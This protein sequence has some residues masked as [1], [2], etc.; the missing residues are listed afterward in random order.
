MTRRSPGA[1]ESCDSSRRVLSSAHCKADGRRD[2]GDPSTRRSGWCAARHR[3]RALGLPQ[4]ARLFGS[5]PGAREYGCYERSYSCRAGRPPDAPSPARICALHRS[6]VDTEAIRPVLASAAGTT[7]WPRLP[8][9]LRRRRSC[10]GA[11]ARASANRHSRASSRGVIATNTPWCGGSTRK[12]R[13]YH[14]GVAQA[15]RDV[16]ARLRQAS[17]SPSRRA[18]GRDSLLAGFSRPALLVFRQRRG[19]A[20]VCERGGDFERAGAGNV[21]ARRL[22]SRHRRHPMHTFDVEWRHEYCC[23]KA[24]DRISRARMPA[25]SWTRSGPSASTGAWPPASLR[26]MRDDCAA[27]LSRTHGDHLKGAPAG[28]EYPRSVSQRLLQ[29]SCKRKRKPRATASSVRLHASLRMRSQTNSSAKSRV[30]EMALD[31]ALGAPSTLFTPRIFQI[32]AQLRRPS[33]GANAAR[34]IVR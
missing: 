25:P 4:R 10:R 32:I 26:G 2:A 9:P 6:V 30:D 28:A 1:P 34:D 19:R 14:R 31:E 8:Q 29:R 7:S 18:A 5:R 20:A 16:Y 21:A 15:R 27:P 22:L 13:H 24:S 17:P 23:A 11:W 12:R 33:S 3:M